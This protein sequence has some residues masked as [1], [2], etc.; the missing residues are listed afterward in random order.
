MVGLLLWVPAWGMA[1]RDRARHAREAAG[2]VSRRAYLM[3]VSG[4]SVV[5]AMGSSAFLVW[6]A[7]RA[8]LDSGPSDDPAWAIA[9][10][11]VAVVVLLY[12]LWQLRR[13]ARAADVILLRAAE[14]GEISQ[15]TV[16]TIEIIAPPDAD[17]R[18]L[19][20]AIRSEL[21]D[22][23]EMRIHPRSP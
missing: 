22:G 5:A 9:I 21:P 11:T 3:L 7:T 14:S 13:D 6:Q 20:A 4:L 2:A 10:L 15:H 1:Q 23:Y 19:N 17:F 16:E 12:H 8:L 18:V